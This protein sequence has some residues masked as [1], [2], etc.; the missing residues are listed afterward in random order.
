MYPIVSTVYRRVSGLPGMQRMKGKGASL[1]QTSDYERNEV[2][3]PLLDQKKRVTGRRDG[4]E[5]HE[6]G[7]CRNTRFVPIKFELDRF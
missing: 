1:T 6:D 3:C 4:E 2:P 7:I 5:D